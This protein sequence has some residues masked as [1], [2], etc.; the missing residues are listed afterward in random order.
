MLNADDDADPDADTHAVLDIEA[1]HLK[2]GLTLRVARCRCES[3]LERCWRLEA[4][5]SRCSRKGVA[6]S[7]TERCAEADCCLSMGLSHNGRRSV[8]RT[9]QLRPKVGKRVEL[10]WSA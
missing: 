2:T 5:R 8:D 1:S 4:I 7:T 9:G 3:L 6:G 10:R